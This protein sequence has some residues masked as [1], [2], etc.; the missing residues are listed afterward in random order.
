VVDLAF[1]A[2]GE[3]H[4]ADDL[5]EVDRLADF[6]STPRDAA[7]ER[8]SDPPTRAP[9]RARAS[10]EGLERALLLLRAHRR[11]FV[12]HL[13]DH[14]P[15]LVVHGDG[16]R[17]SGCAVLRGVVEEVLADAAHPLATPVAEH[18][19]ISVEAKAIAVQQLHLVDDLPR[20]LPHLVIIGGELDRLAVR[21]VRLSEKTF[22]SGIQV[23]K[24]GPA[25]VKIYTPAKTVADCFRFRNQI[26]VDVAVEALRFCLERKRAKPSEILRYA[27]LWRVDRVLR[28]Y[29]EALQ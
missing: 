25:K 12:V 24:I 17:C 16:D 19:G 10:L 29:L 27:R 9:A 15:V 8:Q 6:A 14:E 22:S 1:A 5:R 26:G 13:E 7:D 4:F 28:P 11:S 18:A 3:L 23:E 20:E 2:V 21:V